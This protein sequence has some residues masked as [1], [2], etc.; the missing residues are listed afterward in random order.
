MNDKTLEN[1]QR[2]DLLF[3]VMSSVNNVIELENYKVD[4]NDIELMS[5]LLDIVDHNINTQIKLNFPKLNKSSISS[6]IILSVLMSTS[7]NIDLSKDELEK[8][9]NFK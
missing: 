2:Q 4:R 8:I 6:E 9:K 3:A 7:Y 1:K 5:E